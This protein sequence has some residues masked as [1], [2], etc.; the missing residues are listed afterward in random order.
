M[1]WIYLQVELPYKPVLPHLE[2]VALMKVSW[3]ARF[4]WLD[5]NTDSR[6]MHSDWKVLPFA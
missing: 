2:H 6:T 3:L 5:G 1:S 4:S